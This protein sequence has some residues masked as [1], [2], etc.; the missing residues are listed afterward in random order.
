[1][2]DFKSINT[3]GGKN[4]EKQNRGI[5]KKKEKSFSFGDAMP[6]MAPEIYKKKSV[7]R[8]P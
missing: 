4:E 6:E 8:L 1:M 3:V 5:R 2:K 7:Q